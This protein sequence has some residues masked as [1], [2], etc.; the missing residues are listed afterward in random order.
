MTKCSI[1]HLNPPIGKTQKLV[2]KE[3]LLLPWVDEGGN[4][5]QAAQLF[6]RKAIQAALFCVEII[7]KYQTCEKFKSICIRLIDLYSPILI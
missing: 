6:D 4:T 3:K 7:F 1:V 5:L 2:I